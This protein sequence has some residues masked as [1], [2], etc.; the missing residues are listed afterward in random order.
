VISR[1][2]RAVPAL[3]VVAAIAVPATAVAKGGGAGGTPAPAPVPAGA[4]CATIAALNAGVIDKPASGKPIV[5]DFKVANCGSTTRT[6]STTLTGSWTTITSLEPFTTYTCT[7]TPF[8][9][10]QLTLRAGRTETISVAP[11]YPACG[12]NPWGVNLQYDITYDV[13]IADTASGAVLGSTTSFV[14]RRGGV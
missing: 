8:S 3:C 5:L 9:A 2:L 6:L 11:R 4:P 1:R 12:V 7:G 14:A 10:P 13:T